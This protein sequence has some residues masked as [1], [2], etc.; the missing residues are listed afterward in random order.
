[1]L[2]G[3]IVKSN[4]HIDYVCQ[5]YG[6]GEVPEPPPR[7]AHPFGA[8]V[9][10]ELNGRDRLVG[11]VYNSMLFNPEFGRFGPR[12]SSEVDLAVFSPDYLQEKALLLGIIAVGVLREQ[13]CLQGVPPVSA[14]GEARVETLE[15]NLVRRFHEQRGWLQVQYLPLLQAQSLPL[16]QILARRVVDQ[17]LHLFPQQAPLLHVLADFFAW[18]SQVSPLGGN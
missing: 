18:Q 9:S 5:V 10:I 17:L 13:S 8:F 11:L 3:K 12:L 4:S 6:R 1:M 2:L 16:A 14:A 15:S 7:E